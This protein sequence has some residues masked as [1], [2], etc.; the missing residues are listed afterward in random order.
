[1]TL[2]QLENAVEYRVHAPDSPTEDVGPMLKDYLQLDVKLQEL[3]SKWAEVDEHFKSKAATFAGVR[4]LRQDP[5]ENLISFICTSNNNIGR[6]TLMISKLCEKYG[7]AMGTI[8]SSPP[9]EMYAFPTLEALANDQIEPELREMG[10]GYRAKFIAQTAK[11]L[12]DSHPDPA[13][14]LLNLRKQPYDTVREELLKCSGIGPKVADCIALM[15]LDK[16]DA[17]P[18]DVHVWRIAVRDYGLKGVDTKSMTDKS[19]LKISQHFKDLFGPYAGWTLS[20]LFTSDLRAFTEP[21]PKATKPAKQMKKRKA[22]A[23]DA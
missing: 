17:V 4:V 15:S 14:F 22:D 13:T 8:A 21:K 20:V 23:D 5:V 6:I 9:V 18:V 3:Y 11:M 12:V 16:T 1:V 19:Y 2:K 10:F 7:R